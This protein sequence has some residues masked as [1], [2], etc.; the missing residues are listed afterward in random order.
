MSLK[1]PHLLPLF[2]LPFFMGCKTKDSRL[3][4]AYRYDKNG[5]VY[6]HLEGTPEQIGYQHGYL[7]ADEI[8]DNIKATQLSLTHDTAGGYGSDW[9]FYRNASKNMLWPKIDSEYREEMTGIAEGMAA[10]GKT[11]DVFDIIALNANIELGQYYVPYLADLHKPGSANNRAPGNCSAFIA[12]GSY[13]TDG[14][15]AI[16]HNNWSNYLQ[17]ERWNVVADIVPV[18]GNHIFMDMMPGFIHSGDDFVINGGG[19]LITETTITQFKGFDTTAVAEFVRARKAE[20]YAN[21]IDDFVRIMSEGNNGGYANDWLV[22]DINH[23]EIARVEL[24]LKHVKVWKSSDGVFV[25]SNFASDSSVIADET[26]FNPNDTTNSPYN[27]KLRW[28]A[29]TNTYKGKIDD[30]TGRMMEGDNLNARSGTKEDTR[31]VLAGSVDTDPK[32]CPEWGWGPYYPGGTVQGKITTATMARNFQFWAH[33]GNPSG[34]D[35]LAGPFLA[36]HPEY[37]WQAPL[38]KDTKA[39]PWTLFK[40]GDTQ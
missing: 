25:G 22:G 33:M 35:F 11:Y 19:L 4:G 6:V 27:R 14:K 37:S 13:T 5:W 17:G 16:G 26:T 18:K 8:D 38:L 39:Y 40:A 24:G 3:A 30:S 34:K 31:C 32:G 23:N 1:L 12:T 36:A 9:T 2:I 20:Q 7:L 21:T 29:L 28:E 10:K 15:I